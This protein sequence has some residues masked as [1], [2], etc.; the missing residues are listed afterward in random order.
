MT[1]KI[2]EVIRSRLGVVEEILEITHQPALS[3]GVIHH[4]KEVFRHNRGIINNET[5]Q[6]PNSDTLYCIASLSKAFVSAAIDILVQR[7]EL[8]WDT[9]V[10][11]VLPG[12][13]RYDQDAMLNG[14]TL[15][16]IC[17]HRTG[18][19]GLDEII[20]G[21]DGRILLP[22]SEVVNIVN[23]LPKKFGF[24]TDFH[25]NNALFELAGA[26]IE[27]IS[28]SQTW[29]HF[30]KEELFDPLE[31]KRTTA[32]RNVHKTDDN[33]ATPYMCLTDGS[34]CK[35]APTELSADSMNGGSGGLRSSVNDLL[36]WCSSLLASFDEKSTAN[37]IRH[38]SPI[39]DRANMANPSSVEDGDYCTGWCYHQTPSKLGLISPNRS[40]LS[41]V[42]GTNS[43]SLLVYGHQGDVPG[44]TCSLYL[45]PKTQSAIVVLSNGTGLSDATDWI[46]QDILQAMYSLKP[47]VDFVFNA[48]QASILYKTTFKRL[49]QL[50]LEEHRKMGTPTPPLDD[51]TGEYVMENLDIATLNIKA[52][53]ETSSTGLRMRVN[54]LADQEYYLWHYH[55]D[56][57]CYL[58]ESADQCLRR[59]LDR[60][61]WTSYLISFQRDAEGQVEKLGWDMCGVSVVF[62]K[63]K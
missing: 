4:G 30:L 19:H 9:T 29:G 48:H 52:G 63:R 21:M 5:G 54:G 20:Q 15:R 37:P 11:Q 33:I 44:Y 38:R 17:S 46:A 36:K 49:F 32:F 59:G 58:P 60:S 14:M 56:V 50:P 34:L 45:I 42:L 39:F 25:Y 18:L 27:R 40:L 23:A 51:F 16:D 1:A 8:S 47:T 24:R 57:W 31:M 62:Y 22:K 35:I 55:V 7:Q 2:E 13:G 6:T 53:P 61:D 26:I 3:M 41:P 28:G 10:A 12:Y 43:E